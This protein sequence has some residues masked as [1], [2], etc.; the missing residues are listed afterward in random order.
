[1]RT[2]TRRKGDRKKTRVCDTNVAFHQ[3]ITFTNSL[4]YEE[5]Y[6]RHSLCLT[7]V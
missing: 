1:M 5:K 7:T 4:E 6:Q 3:L 2:M